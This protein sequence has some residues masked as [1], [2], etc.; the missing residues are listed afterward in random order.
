MFI[1]FLI[2][3]L[4]FI[5]G[6]KTYREY[7]VLAET[8][9]TPVRSIPMGLVRVRG[10]ATG[11]DR[12][13]SPLTGVPCFYYQ[14]RLEKWVKKENESGKWEKVGTETGERPFYLDDGT[15]KVLVTP[16]GAQFEVRRTFHGEIG[17]ESVHSRHVD[18]SLGVPGPT[19]QDLAAYVRGAVRGRARRWKRQTLPGPRPRRKLRASRKK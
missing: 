6:F 9:E 17:M 19:E 12:L 8:P 10:T 15:G 13:T 1:A 14:V 11:D 5:F 18:P 2:G 4:L 7:R 16:H 3:A